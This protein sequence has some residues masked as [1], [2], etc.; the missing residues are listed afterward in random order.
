MGP[1]SRKHSSPS[2]AQ[3][4]EDDEDDEEVQPRRPGR[5]RRGHKPTS[6]QAQLGEYFSC[7]VLVSDSSLTPHEFADTDKHAALK[8]KLK[9]SEKA[10]KKLKD[11]SARE[12]AERQQKRAGMPCFHSQHAQFHSHT[13]FD[14]TMEITQKIQ[15]V[16]P[17]PP[18]LRA[19]MTQKTSSRNAGIS[20]QYVHAVHHHTEP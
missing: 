17:P 13:S 11:K 6:K 4:V 12:A 14:Q 9:A 10:Y 3:D 15:A 19:K 5:P 1:K 2:P 20:H 7:F 16:D 18:V 8:N